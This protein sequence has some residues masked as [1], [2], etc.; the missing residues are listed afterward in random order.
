M[1][2]A[3]KILRRHESIKNARFLKNLFVGTHLGCYV[4]LYLSNQLT[5]GKNIL[6]FSIRHV[7]KHL[8]YKLNSLNS[9]PYLSKFHA[10]MSRTSQFV[11]YVTNFK[12]IM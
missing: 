12:M 5:L 9:R 11:P 7:E 6:G 4:R 2:T 8:V 3:A 1:G 10:K